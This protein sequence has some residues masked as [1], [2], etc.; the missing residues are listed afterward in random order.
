MSN[1]LVF[2]I[3][4]QAKECFLAPFLAK[5]V[6]EA[7]RFV[8]QQMNVA[9]D[10]LFALYPKYYSLYSIGEFDSSKGTFVNCNLG[11]RSPLHKDLGDF[12]AICEE[13][14]ADDN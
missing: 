2:S 14:K 4:D 9:S 10:S 1:D 6:L 12:K 5:T 3:Y 11:V 8:V 13:L 7:K